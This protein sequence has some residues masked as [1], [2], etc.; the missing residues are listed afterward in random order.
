MQ[1]TYFSCFINHHQV[2]VADELYRLT[3][4]NYNFICVEDLP[5][6]FR[7]NGYANYFDREYIVKAYT[8]EGFRRAIYLA[9]ESD[10]A[11]FGGNEDVQPFR[12]ARMQ[13]RNKLSFEC[14]ERWLKR[15]IMNI[16]SPRLI[17]A[18]FRYHTR[19]KKNPNYYNLSISA[20]GAR[21]YE[22]MHSFIGKNYKWAYFPEVEDF[23]VM[24]KK[25]T[26]KRLMWCNRFIRWKHPELAIL[27]AA[28]LKREGYTFILDMYG[29]GNMM[30]AM[31]A[32]VD[33]L[34]VADVVTFCGTAPNDTIR[35]AMRNH[36]ILLTTS[37]RNEGWGATVNEGMANG[38]VVIG[39]DEVGSVPRLITDGFNGL[40]FKAN[41][42]D[43]LCGKV[44]QALHN[45][46]K[47]RMM[48]KNAYI[49][50][51]EIWC[52]KNG[53]R[54]LLH[55]CECLLAGKEVDIKEGPCSL[56]A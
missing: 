42:I 30:D 33:K 6:T 10:V 53:S 54:Q 13:E 21:D 51:K 39:A 26:G 1:I 36:D 48:A 43:S 7:K 3:D 11:I 17:K 18:Q 2:W 9:K 49:T 47:C 45:P 20:Y 22:A 27:M 8:P 5:E 41:D 38:C 35:E 52:P 16:L 23:D 32:L 15:G 55:L 4:G 25:F 40:V 46:E 19:Y 28:R 34:H 44:K 14:G 29:G 50:M 24:N 31:K 12:E 37:D 56:D